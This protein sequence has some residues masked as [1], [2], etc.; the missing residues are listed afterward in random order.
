MI[1][2]NKL[3][4]VTGLFDIGRGALPED[5]FKRSFDHYIEAFKKLLKI[6]LPM[7]IYLEPEYEHIVWEIRTPD[8]THIVSKTLDDLRKFPFYDQVQKIRTDPKWLGQRAWIPNSTQAQ[9]ELYNP[10]VMS[11]QFFLN[12]ATLFNFFDTKYFLWIDA[13]ISNTLN[14][15][16]YIK[17]DFEQRIIPLLDKMLY[18]CFP[19]N[20]EV[21]VHGFPKDKMNQYA[22]VETKWVAR[23]GI[24]GGSKAAINEIND[25]YYNILSS[26][27]NEGCMGTEESIFT[28]ITY[29]HP[30]KCILKFIEGNGLIYKFLEE[31]NKSSII[32]P[33][34]FPLAFYVLTY[35]MP[36][37]F[38][39]WVDSF[40]EVY[41][42]YF[43]SVKKYVINNTDD[44]TVIDEYAE[45][46]EHYGFEE[47]KFDN[48]GI[49]D[50]RA[51]AAKHFDSR[52]HTYMI[53]FEDD[54]LF[55][56]KSQ[57]DRCKNGFTT[58]QYDVFS[59]CMEIM[60]NENL[61]YLKLSF[62]EFYGDCHDNW[63]WYNVPRNERDVLF[64]PLENPEIT[65]KTKI[66]YTGCVR[67]LSYA[68]GEYHYCNWPIMF[69]K[70]GNHKVFLDVE[71]DH[72]Y[73]QTWMS[74]VMMMM[75]KHE[76]KAGCLLATPIKHLRM[77][78]YDG[79]Q[80]AEN[81]HY[82]VR[83]D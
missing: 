1:K 46:F 58:Y 7:V 59:K 17:S 56:S 77:Y 31:L 51:E 33:P 43:D 65:K 71:Y 70:A 2:P 69:N 61:D 37:Q 72:K 21:E 67:G 10:L 26:S 66:A 24:F 44:D 47:F 76:I 48:I 25:I 41:P 34:Q 81:R 63:A 20:G 79:E 53:F 49:C 36:K 12:D 8:N 3:T 42:E 29:I 27:I 60:E 50:G 57:E 64:P 39:L 45:L 68:I 30:T 75:N 22:D 82:K 52:D 55:Y 80:R 35:N 14:L 78:H 28:I 40:K 83:D 13:G 6:D 38:K 23:G 11:K 54:M 62:S 18:I 32:E 19:Y 9:L 16:S 4:I 5:G 73:E 74:F 15:D